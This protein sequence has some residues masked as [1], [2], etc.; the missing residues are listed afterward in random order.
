M[1]EESTREVI[2]NLYNFGRWSSENRIGDATRSVAESLGFIGKLTA[3]KE[4]GLEEATS[5][6]VQSLRDVGKCA[7]KNQLKDATSQA[8]TS[9]G[10]VGTS[11]VEKGLKDVVL[12]VRDSLEEV[13]MTAEDNN[14]TIA[15]KQKVESLKRFGE[16]AAG[17]GEVFED[18][19]ITMVDYIGD[20]GKS[21][22]KDGDNDLT[23]R[24]VE[25]LVY[26]GK[27]TVE[28]K[29][30]GA[31]K[32]V[33]HSI[34]LVGVAAAEKGEVCRDATE[35]AIESLQ[36]HQIHIT[37]STGGVEFFKTATEQTA[38]SFIGIGIPAIENN[39]DGVVSGCA[40]CFV[41]WTRSC[42]ELEID[43]LF[44]EWATSGRYEP[45]HKFREI[46]E[47]LRTQTPQQ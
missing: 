45:L 38:R 19:T 46:C 23:E 34:G 2:E 28:Q 11:A 12:Q 25:S 33:A 16:T 7:A 6:A 37:E 21:A 1:D 13:E 24:A 39:L 42:N 44:I 20:V 15:T 26:V 32:E 22:A 40:N 35:H 14:L 43:D 31:T 4:E 47:E 17:K 18:V 29:L 9:L 3:E 41:G 30:E 27:T 36:L 5:Q 10:D 8:V